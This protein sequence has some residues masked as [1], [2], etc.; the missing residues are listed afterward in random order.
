MVGALWQWW[1]RGG[2]GCSIAFLFWYAYAALLAFLF[3]LLTVQTGTNQLVF[4]AGV[5]LPYA[6]RAWQSDAVQEP[7]AIA[8]D[9]A[10]FFR[11][12]SM[13]GWQAWQSRSAHRDRGSG[14]GESRQEDKGSRS[15]QD[16]AAFRR[17]QA[18]RQ[19]EARER[20]EQAERERH[21]E[22]RE[23]RTSSSEPEARS[24]EEILGLIPP[25]TQ[26]DLKTAY[27]RGRGVP[28]RTNGL[29]SRKRYA[30]PW[31]RSTKPSKKPTGYSV[32]EAKKTEIALTSKQVGIQSVSFVIHM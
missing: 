32:G 27:K 7:L 5:L 2:H 19:Q 21:R 12:L 25:W 30:K 23:E 13:Q 18:R 24:P 26:E 11:R 8:S 3:M 15:S 17:E 1:R 9:V 29:V 16:E 31:K 28:T 6:R 14:E 10:G 4:L 22:E 20:R